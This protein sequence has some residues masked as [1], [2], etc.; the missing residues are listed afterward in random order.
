MRKTH[1]KACLALYST[2]EIYRQYHCGRTLYLKSFEVVSLEHLNTE[3]SLTF[4][5]QTTKSNLCIVL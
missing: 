1:E 2:F 4:H 5:T 3:T